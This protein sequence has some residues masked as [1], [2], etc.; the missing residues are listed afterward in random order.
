MAQLVV[1]QHTSHSFT[2]SHM[3]KQYLYLLLPILLC[4]PISAQKHDYNWI[5]GYKNNS[6]DTLLGGATIDFNFKPPK[7]FVDKKKIDLSFYCGICSD[8]SGRLAFYTNGISI[9]DRTHNLM[10]FGDTI[11]PGPFWEK[12][13]KQY[14]PSGPGALTIPAPGKKSQYYLFHLSMQTEVH[15]EVLEISPFYYTLIDMTGN[16]GLG[17]V[18]KRKNRVLIA[19]GDL[20]P[21]VGVKHGNGRD[22]W[23]I[24]GERNTN[25]IYI[26]L[27]NPE[28]VQGPFLTEMPYAFPGKEYFA[29]NSISPDGRLYVRCSSQEGLYI[30]SFNRCNGS[31]SNLKVLPFG[32]DIS[33]IATIFAPDSRHLYLSSSS[34]L[35]VLDLKA[36]DIGA[37]LDT[38]AYYDGFAS[39]FY[40]LKTGFWFPAAGPD[41]KIYYATTNSTLSM[42]YIHRPDWPGQ[43]ADIE[44]HGLTLPKLN[45]GTMCQFPNYRLGEW[46]DAPCDTLQAQVPGDGFEYTWFTEAD[47]TADKTGYRLLPPI[48]DPQKRN[49]PRQKG[50]E[51]WEYFL[52]SSKSNPLW[53]TYKD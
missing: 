25:K 13:Q 34:A 45:Y 17:K 14:F 20:T 16:N 48:G 37:T 29:L 27:V 38:L 49:T 51:L 50:R 18:T 4:G 21:A 43:S 15:E 6:S 22:W 40:P 12:W 2:I 33:V 5:F 41:G 36:P 26:F 30:L 9:R 1:C 19:K 10:Q 23:V 53:H 32:P 46:Q 47:K 42:H 39:P 44:Q 3:M 52:P 7:V 31:F 24:I 8:S 35:M 11:N 28:G